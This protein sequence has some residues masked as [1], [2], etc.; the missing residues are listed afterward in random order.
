MSKDKKTP[1][2]KH[3]REGDSMPSMYSSNEVPTPNKL[4]EN[5]SATSMETLEVASESPTATATPAQAIPTKSSRPSSRKRRKYHQGFSRDVLG[6]IM[7]YAGHRELY[8]IAMSSKTLLEKLTLDMVV[9][10]AFV[11][12]NKDAMA[13][14]NAVRNCLRSG[15]VYLPSPARLLRLVNA[16]GCEVCCIKTAENLTNLETFGLHCCDA[17]LGRSLIQG[18]NEY[19]DTCRNGHFAV[20][21]N[22]A[23]FRLT[24]RILY[25][26]KQPGW[27]SSRNVHVKVYRKDCADGEIAGPIVTMAHVN[28][29]YELTKDKQRR[30]TDFAIVL[31]HDPSDA[32]VYHKF[33]AACTVGKRLAEQAE[34]FRQ[35]HRKQSILKT[36]RNKL[37]NLDSTLQK[38]KPKLHSDIRDFVLDR[39]ADET[40]VPTFICPLV[41]DLLSVRGFLRAPTKVSNDVLDEVAAKLNK[42]LRPIQMLDFLSADYLSEDDPFES[43]IKP[44]FR[45]TFPNLAATAPNLT[46]SVVDLIDEGSLVDAMFHLASFDYESTAL[47]TK[48]LGIV[49]VTT[50]LDARVD[51]SKLQGAYW[52]VRFRESAKQ[53]PRI[54]LAK[55]SSADIDNV[56]TM[57][58]AFL[59]W[60]GAK[61]GSHP[62]YVQHCIASLYKPESL[63]DVCEGR[64]DQAGGSEQRCRRSGGTSFEDV[65]V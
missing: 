18:E 24:K 6:I 41:H 1:A 19:H 60:A 53:T 4:D 8:T 34:A 23:R 52:V 45:S 25:P 63:N 5:L 37:A 62:A 21:L 44:I 33:M 9:K 59:L 11:S 65:W 14:V 22:H 13:I 55:I 51:L 20:A 43:R 17:C 48:L 29:I 10:S 31:G 61:K 64:F 26:G 49:Q 57:A 58:N 15:A 2:N 27:H 28:Q 42:K 16:K 39:K 56:V 32:P 7:E 30:G 36:A 40:Y 38:L 54:L 50:E 3:S 35:E 12:G 47:G 46:G